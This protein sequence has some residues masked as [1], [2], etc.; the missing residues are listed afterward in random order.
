M[1]RYSCLRVYLCCFFWLL[2]LPVVAFARDVDGCLTCHQYP[3]LVRPDAS[4]LKVFH[5]DEARYEQSPHG[6][7]SCR[8]CHTNINKIPHDDNREV[9]CNNQCH[10]SKKDR[11]M[12]QDYDYSQLHKNEQAYISKMH[13]PTSCR[14][15][16]ALYPHG[17]NKL[18][19]S[20]INMHT[21]FM[22]CEVCHI[23]RDMFGPLTYDWDSS[24]YVEFVGEPYGT[25]YDPRAVK[26]KELEHYLA[27]ITVLNV[28]NGETR[29]RLNIW[30]THKAREF[31]KQEPFIGMA[32]KREQLTYFH[33]DIAKKE[34]SAACEDCHSTESILDFQQLGFSDLK[35]RELIAINLKGLVTKYD[36]FYLPHIFP[37]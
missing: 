36:I 13:D 11:Q 12:L 21:G 35:A 9:K 16:H 5:I 27:R 22:Y 33:R 32:G 25:R 17:K 15:C 6:K 37:R 8:K 18:A 14:V 28:V 29:S 20:L 24:D 31:K 3:G 26:V 10:K 19:G 2:S 4:G 7:F 34:I 23:K 30:D 1:H